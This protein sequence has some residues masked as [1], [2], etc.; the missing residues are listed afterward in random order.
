MSLKER[1]KNIQWGSVTWLVIVWNLLWGE[2]SWGNIIGG[3]ILSVLVVIVMPLPQ[4]EFKGRIRPAFVLYLIARF[5]LDLVAASFQVALQA[6]QFGKTP[7]GAIIRVKLRSDSDLYM[8]LTSELSCLVP[9]SLV[10]EAHPLSQTLYVHVLDLENYGGAE[11]V[12]VDVLA[13]EARV[14]RAFASQQEL[15]RAG[16]TLRG[17]AT[18]R[19]DSP[20]IQ[21]SKGADQ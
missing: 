7:R 14:M 20:E 12:R 17:I 8:T 1:L 6:F 16:L 3:F 11:K 5:L 19:T 21:D 9:G 15:D 18:D 10:V 4:I 13:L 2:F